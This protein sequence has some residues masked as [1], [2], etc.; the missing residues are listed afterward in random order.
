MRYQQ[1]LQIME[2]DHGTITWDTTSVSAGTYYYNCSN[3]SSMFGRII[4]EATPAA[5]TIATGTTK[6]PHGLTRTSAVK[7][8]GAT[9]NAFNGTFNVKHSLSLP[10][11]II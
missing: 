8:K 9:D 6:Y 2:H 1:V 4:V 5:T 3:H 11:V 10:L 7:I